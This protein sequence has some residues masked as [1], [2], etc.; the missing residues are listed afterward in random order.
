M[1]RPTIHES[2]QVGVT[3]STSTIW[4][5]HAFAPSW[6]TT[7]AIFVAIVSALATDIERRIFRFAHRKES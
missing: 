2:V 1:R 4:I 3:A 5:A 6:E 7:A